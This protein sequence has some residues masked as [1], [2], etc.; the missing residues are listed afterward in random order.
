VLFDL[1]GVLTSTAALHARCWKAVFDELLIEP[2]DIERDYLAHVDGKPRYDGVRDFM[3][4]RGIELS[5]ERVRVIG[6]HKQALVERALE[7]LPPAPAGRVGA[8][9]LP[10]AGARPADRGR[11]D[12][13]GDEQL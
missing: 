8:P 2:F 5:E 7:G 9:A 13:R 3:R 12:P 11:H 6:D 10:G 4:S 1:D